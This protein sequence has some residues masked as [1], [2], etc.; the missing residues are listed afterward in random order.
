MHELTVV[1]SLITQVGAEAERLGVAGKV[2]VVHLK[3]GALTT[4]VG[5]AMAFCFAALV[6]ETPLEGARLAVEEIPVGGAC[7]ACGAP[8]TL[9]AP[10]FCCPACGSADVDITSGRELEV[11]SLEVA[12]DEE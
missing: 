12:D 3:L 5:E 1:H 4:F 8:F 10:P 6:P 2:K 9:E 11:E 7:R